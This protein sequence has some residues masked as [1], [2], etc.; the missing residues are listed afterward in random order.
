[1]N[2]P[3]TD[4]RIRRTRKLLGDA[5]VELMLEMAYDKITIQDIIDRANVGRSTFYAHYRNKEDLLVSDFE[6]V[7]GLLSGHLDHEGGAVS[8]VG[9]FRHVQDHHYLYRALA[10]GRGI[11]MLFEKGQ[12]YLSERIEEHLSIQ[13]SREHPPSVPL[14]LLANFLAGTILMLVKWWL[15]NNMPYSPERMDEIYTQL[16][17]PGATAVMSGQV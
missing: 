13:A 8:V 4:R 3:S 7:L 10:R 11:E 5:L 15:D 17:L 14:P 9:L 16:I 6:H 2:H 1:M 12:F